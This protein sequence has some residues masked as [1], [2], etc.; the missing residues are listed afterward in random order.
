LSNKSGMR[1]APS[2]SSPRLHGAKPACAGWRTPSGESPRLARTKP[3][4]AAYGGFDLKTIAIRADPC[5]I[6][7]NHGYTRIER[8]VTDVFFLNPCRSVAPVP[9]RVLFIP[10]PSVFYFFCADKA[11]RRARLLRC[12]PLHTM[13]FFSSDQPKSIPHIGHYHHHRHRAALHRCHYF[14]LIMT[15]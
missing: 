11:R 9:I 7:K 5:S 4:C 10:C 8:I 1:R 14:H 6:H 12:M 3:A 15:S 2:G 13:T